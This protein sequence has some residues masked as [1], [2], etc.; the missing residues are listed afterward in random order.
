MI[1]CKRMRG[2][3][4]ADMQAGRARMPWKRVSR[5]S[6]AALQAGRARLPCKG[7][8]RVTKAT[9]QAGRLAARLPW[10]PSGVSKVPPPESEQKTRLLSVNP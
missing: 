9:I 4:K 2:V 10:N 5:V 3:S 8:S 1:P 6:K 7:A